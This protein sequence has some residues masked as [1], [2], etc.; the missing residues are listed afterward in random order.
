MLLLVA[1]GCA[2]VWG[3]SFEVVGFEQGKMRRDEFGNWLIYEHGREMQYAENGRCLVSGEWQPCMWHGFVL[4][5]RTDADQ[6]S[7]DCVARLSRPTKQVDPSEVLAESTKE[8][9]FTLSLRGSETVFRNPQYVTAP[10]LSRAV[11]WA[12]TQCQVNGRTVLKFDDV[13]HFD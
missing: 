13:I 11:R 2:S 12:D 8:M 6:V 4:E 5:Y 3:P 1:H 9:P 7:L 10:I